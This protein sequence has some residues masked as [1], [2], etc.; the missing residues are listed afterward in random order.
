MAE[1]V[2]LVSLGPSPDLARLCDEAAGRCG[3]Q[4]DQ[5]LRWPG[6][7]AASTPALHDDDLHKV[8]L[9]QGRHGIVCEKLLSGQPCPTGDDLP[10]VE[11]LVQRDG[12]Y[13]T[14]LIDPSA[15]GTVTL[16]SDRLGT[17]PIFC[18]IRGNLLYFSSRLSI[19]QRMPGLR[20]RL[21][22]PAI[23][24][25]LNHK[26]FWNGDTPYEGVR[27]LLAGTYEV[28][29]ATSRLRRQH[30]DHSFRPGRY[31]GRTEQVVQECWNRLCSTV[32]RVL[33]PGMPTSVMLSGG[34]DSALLTAVTRECSTQPVH[35]YSV[36]F[37]SD[38]EAWNEA[39]YSKEVA[40]KADAHYH[41][42]ELTQEYLVEHLDRFID[43]LDLPATGSLVPFMV[44]EAAAADG[45]SLHLN[46]QGADTAFGLTKM[47]LVVDLAEALCPL[48]RVLGP[49]TTCE[50]TGAVHRS[51]S[52]RPAD[53]VVRRLR[54]LRRIRHYFRLRSGRGS[55]TGSELRPEDIERTFLAKWRDRLGQSVAAKTCELFEKA[56]THL[57][58]DMMGY[59]TEVT[60]L[61]NH[62]IRTAG[63]MSG[64]YGQA[65][66]LPF[67]D[68]E[69]L[70]YATTLPIQWRRRT[71]WSKYI[72][73][74][75]CRRRFGEAYA[76]R[77]KMVFAVPLADW[78]KGKLR[79]CADD[80]LRP[81]SVRARGVFSPE[82]LRELWVM[83]ESGRAA[84]VDIWAYIVLEL[85]LRK[86][87]ESLGYPLVA[88][89]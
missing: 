41:P 37:G 45:V 23:N 70:T 6:G 50:L 69:V 28:V 21:S 51:L 24:R 18:A 32:D 86:Q 49:R 85:W 60:Y 55:W 80:A 61:Y 65:M 62:A 83:L 30:W 40:E 34:L 48:A 89:E 19:L 16:V 17:V 54:T 10:Q 33:R 74:E 20:L 76:R 2:G 7:W 1:F 25:Y 47:W 64:W 11:D 46:G 71:G 43:T 12:W 5:T 77:P 29:T 8:T 13:G 58:S 72:V 44:M 36:V 9:H 27:T 38:N 52:C 59:V 67:M 73:R 42:L 3:V 78:L 81:D 35:A 57:F 63:L 14:V 87:E 39:R 31:A 84:W 75:L 66:F 79:P 22:I 56:D 15:Y 26:A 88:G 53:A 4:C 82:A 68:R